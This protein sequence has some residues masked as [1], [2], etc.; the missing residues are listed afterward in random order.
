MRILFCLLLVAACTFSASATEKDS[1]TGRTRL[2]GGKLGDGKVTSGVPYYLRKH[3][4]R[5]VEKGKH[6]NKKARPVYELEVVYEA[7]PTKGFYITMQRGGFANNQFDVNLGEDGRLLSVNA[8]S[9][10]IATEVVGAIG[11]FITTL[12]K[13]E[14][15]LGQGLVLSLGNDT[16]EAGF[17]TAENAGLPLRS[18]EN[19]PDGLDKDGTDNLYSEPIGNP[20][21]YTF[22]QLLYRF[23]ILNEAAKMID[24]EAQKAEMNK[25]ASHLAVMVAASQCSSIRDG[26]WANDFN[27][28]FPAFLRNDTIGEGDRKRFLEVMGELCRPGLPLDVK[29]AIED[30]FTTTSSDRQEL[31]NE[32]TEKKNKA[33]ELLKTSL[34]GNPNAFAADLQSA[35]F[36]GVKALTATD[37]VPGALATA[38]EQETLNQQEVGTI[39]DG[40]TLIATLGSNP[41]PLNMDQRKLLE[42]GS[43]LLEKGSTGL[44]TKAKA[45]VNDNVGKINETVTLESL[46]DGFQY[47]TLAMLHDASGILSKEK[48]VFDDFLDKHKPSNLLLD[49]FEKRKADIELALY[50][51]VQGQ[52][53]LDDLGDKIDEY[54]KGV[55][56]VI[57]ADAYFNQRHLEQQRALL[58]RFLTDKGEAFTPGVNANKNALALKQ[59]RLDLDAVHKIIVGLLTKPKPDKKTP[60]EKGTQVTE[61]YE[62]DELFLLKK[63][64]WEAKQQ[65]LAAMILTY[66]DRKAIIF[67]N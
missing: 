45:I 64:N 23:F 41:A 9:T 67:A 57:Q 47:D 19:D 4:F 39:K 5:I 22:E 54:Q 32:V 51:T 59:I 62:Y 10:S 52:I 63:G 3:R 44:S 61:T 50:Q 26:N 37:P 1:K 58:N 65:K 46:Q 66:T 48:K 8:S 21:Y 17:T 2:V 15:T 36:R 13:A 12:L 25:A 28:L 35:Y 11:N 20:F 14:A 31:R 60:L 42:K 56:A 43:K 53:T 34:D 49:V 16:L 40:R 18:Y 7:D 29:G 55:E 33:L 38:Q 24:D 6:D 30:H 27:R